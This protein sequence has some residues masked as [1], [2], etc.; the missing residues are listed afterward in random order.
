M[1]E[2]ASEIRAAQRAKMVAKAMERGRKQGRKEG[3][4]EAAKMRDLLKSSVVSK[5]PET[6]AVTLTLNPQDANLL[7]GE[8][9]DDV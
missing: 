3:R 1:F 5:D 2:K 6:G 8:T 7:L 9:T 4:Q